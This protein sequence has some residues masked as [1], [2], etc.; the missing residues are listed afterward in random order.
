VKCAKCGADNREGRKF[1]SK[2]GG[3]LA[4]SCPQC[5]TANETGDDF[6]GEC[7]TSL[8][9]SSAAR[10]EQTKAVDPAIK[11][12]PEAPP[13]SLDGER[14]MVTALFA[15]IK[16]SMELM[17][18]LDPE[19]ARAIVDPALKL[20]IDAIHRYGG[21]VV[22]STGDG[23]FALFGA[24]VAHEDHPQRAVYAALRMQEEMRRYGDRMRT[25]GQ[26]P[27]QVRVGVNTGEVVVRSLQ[28]SAHHTE[29]TPIGHS[30]SLAARLQTLAIPGST[31]ISG[32]T[33]GFVEGYFQ[34]KSL[35]PTRVKGVSEPVEVY[36]V[37]GL[38]PLRTRLQ[39]AAVRGLTKFV[40]REREMDTLRHALE[41]A[42]TGHGQIVAAIAEPGVGKSRLFF[43]FKATS[44]AG[45]MVLEAYSVSHGKATA[46]L[47]VIDLLHGYFAV[48]SSDDTRR[49]REKVGGKVLMLDRSLEDTLPYL[50]ALL[51]LG[52]GDEQL[53]R[54]E[55]QIRRRRMHDAIKRILLRESLNQPMM[56]IFEDL[57]W[58]DSE[59]QD[60]LN[61]LVDS[62]GTAR[63]LLLVNYRPEYQHQW[64]SRI[65]YTQLRLDPLGTQS[66]EEMLDSLVGDRPE[67]APL[68][69]V[70]IER[71]QGNPFFIEEIVLALFDDGALV[72][73]G[74]VK[75]TR[76]FAELKIPP[77]VQATLA[78]RIDRLPA[79]EKE[80]LQILAVI[81][82][83]IAMEAIRHVTGRSEEQL[84]ALLSNLQSSEFINE[85]PTVGGTEYLFKHA[86]TQEVSYNTLLTE[87]RR[88]LHAQA[89]R[90]IEAVYAGHLEDHYS[91]LARHHLRGNDPAKAVRYAQLAAEQ[92]ANRGAYLEAINLINA[93]LDLL[94]RIPEGN[95]RLRTELALRGSEAAVA[96][97]L[98]GPGSPETHRSIR[99]MCELGEKL[100]DPELLLRGL[101]GLTGVHFSRS[102]SVQGREVAKRCFQL[103]R[104]V[105]DAALLADLGY[106]AGLIAFFLGNFRES[107][108]HLEEAA[109]QSSRANRR[110][111][112]MGLLYASSIR[113]IQAGTLQLFG[114]VGDAA[115]SIEEGLRRAREARLPVSLA[116]ALAIGALVTHYRRQPE[117]TLGY[118][119]EGI[120]LSEENGFVL[121]LVMARYLRGCAMAEL[122]QIEQGVADIEAALKRVVQIGGM[123]MQS[124]LIAQLANAHGQMGNPLKALAMLEEAH[125]HCERTGENRDRAELHRLQGELL[126]M[127]NAQ[128]TEQAETCF[129]TGLE[130][131]R[132]QEAKWWELRASVS[133]ARLL[134]DTNRWHE[135]HTMLAEIYNWFTEGFDLPDLKEA[136]ALL[137]ELSC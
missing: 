27:L 69:R 112:N 81:G 125:A 9:L 56:L 117:L 132:A 26:T 100:E 3:A 98:H 15:D 130:I 83:E 136:K 73:N 63:I 77:T 82:Q 31:V 33:R 74:E 80:L 32:Y 35:G 86:L 5:G 51:G 62:L 40:G 89:G 68:K 104:T 70:I 60:L 23:I 122:G 49:R 76:P 28:T 30:T 115:R 127:S 57:H 113:C 39:R 25:Q 105:Q 123:P 92:A 79:A 50:F 91:E 71:T 7:G 37:T 114:R 11:I 78:A 110:V 44:Q 48:E 134:R 58:I 119:R 99:R 55:P 18:D 131:A 94:D 67:L 36:E 133:L 135:A 10:A 124:V 29:Y 65:H 20:M 61:L 120:A 46:Y 116:H 24:P 45:W 88:M 106:M 95:E 90:A 16:G 6:C 84:E 22:Q 121:W 102:E 38:G 111:S 54:M 129:R 103:A 107:S 52:E 93:A 75:L 4:R 137:Y 53:A 128:T 87:R 97:A 17:E 108:S 64:G 13:E 47:P 43:E 59:T 12:A 14:K 118:A 126:L 96:F 8:A 1:C 85:Q 41:H 42:K 2:C 34:L 19:E 72:R 109:L 101:I 66:A 21:F